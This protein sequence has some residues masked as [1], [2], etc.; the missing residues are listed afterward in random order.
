MHWIM[1]TRHPNYYR[2]NTIY[3]VNGRRRYRCCIKY[4]SN[5]CMII[6]VNLSYYGAVNPLM[7][8]F[9]KLIESLIVLIFMLYVWNHTRHIDTDEMIKQFERYQSPSFKKG[10][11]GW[12]KIE[13]GQI[14]HKLQNAGVEPDAARV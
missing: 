4:G 9:R 13:A 3:I 10:M 11:D 12:Y 2:T 14:E 7:H 1:D 6:S 5:K 8:R